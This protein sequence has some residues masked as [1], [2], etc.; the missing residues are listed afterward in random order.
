MIYIKTMKRIFIFTFL[1]LLST[2]VYAD[3]QWLKKPLHYVCADSVITWGYDGRDFRS[4]ALMVDS[5][6]Q[7][8]A[9]LLDRQ[10]WHNRQHTYEQWLAQLGEHNKLGGAGLETE[11]GQAIAAAKWLNQAAQLYLMQGDA[12][13]MDYAERALMNAV[14]RTALDKTQP[15]GTIDKWLAASLLLGTPGWVYATSANERELYVNL[16]TNA[17]TSLTLNKTR[18]VVDQITDM[19]LSGGVKFRFSNFTGD[20][21]LKLHL[22]MPDWTG[23]RSHVP[24]LF[25]G[26][27]PQ[28]PTIYVNGHEVNPLVV[29]DKGYVVIDRTWHALDEVYIDFPLRAQTILPASTPREQ[30]SAPLHDFAAF[31]YGPLVCLPQG[32]TTGFYFMPNRPPVVTDELNALQRPVLQ[33]TMYRYANTP[34]DAA[35]E[36]QTFKAE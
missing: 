4:I 22:R 25:V 27:E 20:L 23:M 3:K 31:Q 33:G 21:K 7:T 26:G 2:F 24:Y 17:T 14:M 34:Q 36:S 5:T 19:P 30:L 12:C 16:Y 9:M 13:Y 8:K 29:N 10:A 6:A 18:L 32:N 1:A 11:A 28:Q 35:A 15:R